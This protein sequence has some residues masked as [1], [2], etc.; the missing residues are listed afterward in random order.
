MS[1]RRC[2]SAIALGAIVFLCATVI[3]VWVQFSQGAFDKRRLSDDANNSTALHF[4]TMMQ[5]T[6]SKSIKPVKFQS[7]TFEADMSEETKAKPTPHKKKEFIE[8]SHLDD[9][10]VQEA[11][12]VKPLKI[13]PDDETVQYDQNSTVV[14]HHS[15]HFRHKSAEIWDPH[16]KYQIEAF[17][18]TLMLELEHDDK[19]V[20]PGL[21]IVTHGQDIAHRRPHDPKVS[22]CFYTGKLQNDSNSAISVNLCHGMTGYIRSSTANY[23]IEPAENFTSGTLGTILHR[24][25]I[26]PHAL[27]DSNDIL[28]FEGSLEAQVKTENDSSKIVDDDF[29]A[30][31][32][33]RHHVIRK[34]FVSFDDEV[35][36]DPKLH[37]DIPQE[38]L[39]RSRNTD[40]SSGY[41]KRSNEYFI[42]VLVVADSTMLEYHKSHEELTKY[43][44]I[45]MS[46]VSLLFKEA[47]IGNAI[48]VS[49]V[50][51]EILGSPMHEF[52]NSLSQDMLRRFC[53]WKQRFILNNAHD[54]ALLL[55]RRTICKNQTSCAT[56]GVAE[57]DSMCRPSGCTIVRDKGLSTSYT[58]AHEF[59]HTLSMVHD[60]DNK[61]TH[62]NSRTPHSNNIMSRT[63]KNDSKPFM[64]SPCSRQY[65]TD[66][67]DSPRSKCLLYP[68]SNNEILANY[69]Q[70][71]PGDT[72][73]VDRQCEL[74]FGPGHTR[75]TMALDPPCVHLWCKNL[76]GG[77]I[78]QFSPWAEG[79]KCGHRSWCYKRECIAEDRRQFTPIDGGWGYWQPWGECS[80]T[81]GGGIKK[82]VRYCDS[83]TP[84]NG[85][86]YC[87]GKSVQY[88]SCN[89]NDC[90]ETARD[91]REIQCAQYNGITKGL[92]N[93]TQDVQWIPKYGLGSP[94]RVEDYCRLYC[95]PHHSAAYYALKDKVLDG[96]KCGKSGFDICVNGMCRPG[97]CDNYLDSKSQFDECGVCGG[98]NSQCREVA[99]TY[100]NTA[101]QVSYNMVVRIP[102]GSS[103]VKVTQ[104]SYGIDENFL[105][106]R[107]GETGQYIL[108]GNQMLMTQEVEVEYGPMII[109]YSGSNA[110]TEWISTLKTK[111]L[112]KDLVVEVLS[113]KNLSPPDITYHY[114]IRKDAAP[115]VSPYSSYGWRLYQK[116]WSTCSSICEGIQYRKP[117]CVK[118]INGHVADK[119]YCAHN[120]VESATEKRQCN[121]HCSLTWHIESR[122]A[123]SPHCGKGYRH[124]YYK[125]IKLGKNNQ[126]NIQDVHTQHCNVLPKPPSTEICYTSCNS[127]RWDYSNWSE[128]SQTCGG[129]TQTRSAKCVDENNMPIDD[130]HC[131]SSEKIVKQICNIEECPDWIVGE[132]SACSVPCGGGYQNTTY[133]CVLTG[134]IYDAMACDQ[135]TKPP[136]S[137]KC[138]EHACGR[139]A[140]S[141]SFHRCSVT[142]GEGVERRRFVCK[143]FDTEE[144]LDQEYCR[145][146]RLPREETRKC[147][148]ECDRMVPYPTYDKQR[149]IVNENSVYDRYDRYKVFQWVAGNWSECSQTCD[150]GTSTQTFHC[151]NDLGEENHLMCDRYQK[152][153]NVIRCNNHPCPK[154]KVGDWSPNCDSQCERH[155]QVRCMD[156]KMATFSDNQ[157]EMK[158][159]PQ[160]SLK[161][162]LV[163]CPDAASSI[164]R[165]YF[166]PKENDENRFRWKVGA[167]KQCSTNCGKGTRKRIIEC[168]DTLNNSP[169]VD[170]ICRHKQRPK[171]SK[172]CERYQCKF[173]WIE[174]PWDT[175]SATCGH[176]TKTRNVTCH[177]V[178]LGGVVDPIPLAESQHRMMHKSYCDMYT[179]PSSSSKCLLSHCGDEYMW[180][181]AEWKPCTHACGRKGRQF[182]VLNCISVR[183]K[184]KVP[185]HFCPKSLRPIK[186]R[187]CNQWRCLYKSCKEIKDYM[188][189]KENRD[190]LI[191]LHGRTVSVYCYKMDTADPQEYISLHADKEN[192]AEINNRRLMNLTTCPY[193]EENQENCPCNLRSPQK[194]GV[195]R[196]WKVRLNTT[197]LEII[198]DDFTFSTQVNGTR[199]AYGTSGDC[200]S[201][202]PNGCPQGRFSVDL[203]HTSFK[204]ANYVRWKNTGRYPSSQIYRPSSTLIQGICGGFCGECVPDPQYGGLKVEIT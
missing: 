138:N 179:R 103:N 192:Y 154:W 120:D 4:G 191:T 24:I 149:Y 104:H 139:W 112:H 2:T 136:S 131:S 178:H 96:T 188:R 40:W 193:G 128:C 83:P 164:S 43:I 197:S 125:C 78:S 150:G 144:I 133:Y 119:S 196:F 165:N 141:D 5:E 11:V 93:L 118:L 16:P 36:Y 146:I 203:T 17:G 194:S 90:E 189:T 87:T 180:Q 127:T 183:T 97:G 101:D 100:N 77:C 151:R 161:C 50:H 177:K 115:S 7:V 135:R 116:N 63:T 155:R 8:D 66:F 182:R 109:K 28:A 88:K 187:K 67:L 29:P 122:S 19:F 84:E 54:V 58:I 172:P 95:K 3:I 82:S 175:C 117:T 147:F 91:F 201:R 12:F 190:Y 184:Q 121:K 49:V 27:E 158:H 31:I 65:A 114:V 176:G 159:R 163:E 113:I 18:K 173:T 162:P 170:S 99:G 35:L 145:G 22:G 61:C 9:L 6:T 1:R 34:R 73:E 166:D 59:G 160:D 68:P 89:T 79:T 13:N 186:K 10:G 140:A 167:W 44:L 92:P 98:D 137:K 111:K 76:N 204:I 62:H 108:N 47:S 39:R 21:H 37:E 124:V 51:I 48:N 38:Y 152:P 142:C 107:D 64:W 153:Q 25:K 102:K 75:C 157:C 199:I 181:A 55:T 168:E 134:R 15:G 148:K 69:T 85:G 60:D 20:A 72:F 56:L 14:K 94:G 129:G 126:T 123:C 132:T 156:D 171:N 195:T 23:Y 169:V 71:L 106:L 86:N 46:H 105:A 41:T 32:V 200:Y 74:E 52:S 30:E 53:E 110:K 198:G 143:K 202:Y 80:R 174:G 45:L 33:E 185:R 42:K 26:L 70:M 81:C 130:A 57:V